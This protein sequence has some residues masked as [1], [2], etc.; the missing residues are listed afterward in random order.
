MS[1]P[2]P[3]TRKRSP[4][5]ETQTTR[6]FRYWLAHRGPFTIGLF[7]GLMWPASLVVGWWRGVQEAHMDWKADL[8]IMLWWSRKLRPPATPTSAKDPSEGAGP[9]EGG[10]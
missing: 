6:S 10:R 1:E 4:M 3:R 7:F 5:S 9:A 8:G 2:P